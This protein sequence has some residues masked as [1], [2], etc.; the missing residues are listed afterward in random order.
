MPFYIGDYLRDTMHLP[1]ESH[2]SYLL[3]IMAYWANQ[4]PLPDDDDFLS[5]TARCALPEWTQTERKRISKFFQTVNGVWRHTRIDKEI[6]AVKATLEARSRA[7]KAGNEAK[8]RK[9]NAN[10]TQTEPIANALRV[11][12]APISHTHTHIDRESNGEPGEP[13]PSTS[14]PVELPAGFPKSEAEAECAAATVGCG[15][16]FAAQTWNKAASRGGMDAKGVQIRSWSHYLRTEWTYEQQRQHLKNE[17]GTKNNGPAGPNSP[18]RG[19]APD[20]SK[21]F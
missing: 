5:Q 14:E 6:E 19:K 11:Q 21:G 4:G 7:G 12:N 8:L 2:G 15:P 1:R 13:I 9:R 16:D 3:L 17:L 10:G 20:H 18:R